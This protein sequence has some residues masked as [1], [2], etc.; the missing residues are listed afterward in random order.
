MLNVK[1]LIPFLKSPLNEKLSLK[2]LC[3]SGDN[4][5]GD[6]SSGDSSSGS[7]GSSSGSG[8]GG[9]TFTYW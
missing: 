9:S 4:S 5:S 7:D 3:S 6:N 8:S 2:Q 1:K